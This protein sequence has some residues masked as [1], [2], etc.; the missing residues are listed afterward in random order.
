MPRLIDLFWQV[1]GVPVSELY[2]AET[3]NELERVLRIMKPYIDECICFDVVYSP[4]FGYLLID[5]PGADTI[6]D[7]NIVPLD[8]ASTLLHELFT[9]LAY[10]F[11]QE[12]GHCV[13]Y[14][15]ATELEKDALRIWMK[16]YVD[17]L[18]EYQ[19]ILDNLLS[20]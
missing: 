3:K 11:M 13:D 2:T 6:D 5:L 1:K 17:Q 4:K 12:K 10:D 7:A 14:T 18:P 16:K 9:N 19:Y 20:Q 8:E 15:E